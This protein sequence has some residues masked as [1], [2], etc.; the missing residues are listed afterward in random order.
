MTYEGSGGEVSATFRDRAG[1]ERLLRT[2]GATEF[3]AT[4]SLTRGEYGLFRWELNAKAPGPDPHFHRTFSE[5]F[6]VLEGTVSL[7]DGR[8]W[9]EANAGE[10][11]YVPKGG[12]HAFQNASDA[13][14]AMLIL[15]VPGTPRETYF[16]ASAEIAASGRKM[17][18][19]EQTAF[20]ASHD[21]YMVE[22]G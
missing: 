19:E 9:I 17:S 12:I 8:E 20:L 4:G 18:K 7:Y 11:L 1:I 15:F 14:A 21:Q 10:L 22:D 6:Y 13:P 5:S 3:T 16:R 2:T